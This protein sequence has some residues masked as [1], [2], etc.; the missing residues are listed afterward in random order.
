ML[1]I[2]YLGFNPRARTGR[3][4]FARRSLRR[5]SC[6][7][8]RARTGRDYYWGVV[9]EMSRVSIHAPARGAT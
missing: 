7:N 8:P 4:L 1:N 5:K 2:A 3:D 9:I 6:F